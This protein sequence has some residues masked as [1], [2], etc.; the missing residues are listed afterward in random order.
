MFLAAMRTNEHTKAARKHTVPQ[1]QGP[2]SV[3]SL[4]S[5]DPDH[6]SS[7]LKVLERATPKAIVEPS[8]KSQKDELAMP[9]PGGGGVRQTKEPPIPSLAIV[10]GLVEG[11]LFLLPGLKDVTKLPSL[12]TLQAQIVGLLSSPASQLTGVL[13]QAAGGRLART[14]EGFKQGLEEAG[15]SS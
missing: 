8:K 12:E 10:G 6:L 15:K 3:I 9:P 4:P 5:L 11:K 1:L 14:L 13:S 7:I 2:I